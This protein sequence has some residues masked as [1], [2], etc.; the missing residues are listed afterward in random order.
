MAEFKA[1]TE[2]PG[3]DLSFFIL[4]LI[5]LGILWYVQ[6]GTERMA[7]EIYFGESNIGSDQQYSFSSGGQTVQPETFVV[8]FYAFQAKESD[9]Q[10]EYLEIRNDGSSDI[11]VTGW[12][13]KGQNNFEVKI[14][15]AVR[16]YLSNKVN[17]TEDIVL[18]S[19]DK[20]V[21]LTGQGPLGVSF[22]INRC[23]GYFSKTQDFYPPIY[24]ECPLPKDEEWPS[25]L[26][27][28]C[29]DFIDTLPRCQWNFIYPINLKNDCIEA[30]SGTVGYNHCAELHQNDSDFYKKEWRVYLG[31]NEEL[32]KNQRETIVLRDKDGNIVKEVSYR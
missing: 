4:F 25:A 1:P 23:M 10:K 9:P 29:L 18:K 7:N 11:N 26:S 13:I 12:S 19:G 31:R 14:P 20:A 3:R 6:G 15:S 17:T 28:D 21:I 24:E 2:N 27:D 22:L 32:W 5:V 16:F 8:S 30:I